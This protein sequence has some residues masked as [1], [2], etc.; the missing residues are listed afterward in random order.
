MTQ[1][2]KINKLD[3]FKSIKEGLFIILFTPIVLLGAQWMGKISSN[4]YPEVLIFMGIFT[5]ILFIPAIYLHVSYF[6]KGAKTVTIDNESNQITVSSVGNEVKTYK[7]DEIAHSEKNLSIYL[8]NKIDN[9]MRFSAP[10]S[11]YSYLKIRFND[12]NII[13]ITSLMADIET[14]PIKVLETHYALVPFLQKRD[15]V[16]IKVKP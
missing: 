6:I 1:T 2:F 10:W 11:G 8:K 3:Q 5:F 7:L 15:W 12:G 16:T 4:D 13:F 9:K 14:F